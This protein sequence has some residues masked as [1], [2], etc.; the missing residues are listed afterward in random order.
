[1]SKKEDLVSA[2]AD[3]AKKANLGSHRFRGRL[4]E[5]LSRPADDPLCPAIMQCLVNGMNAQ[6][7]LDAMKETLDPARVEAERESLAQA[8]KRLT[9]MAELAP[10]FAD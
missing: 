9:A 3:L 2:F 8:H 5:A 6:Q 1:M 10:L 4:S 7:M